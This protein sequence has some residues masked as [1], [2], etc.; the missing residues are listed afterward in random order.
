MSLSHLHKPVLEVKGLSLYIS[1]DIAVIVM[2]RGENRFNIDFLESMSIVLDHVEKDETCRGL[3][4]TGIGKFYSNGID[5]AWMMEQ[6]HRDVERFMVML[7]ELLKR[8]TIFPVPTVAA[9]NGHCFAG[10]AF[11][12]L[13]HDFRAMKDDG[14]GW[15]CFNEVHNN[16]RFRKP[17]IAFLRI[18]IGVGKAFMMQL[19]W[20]TASQHQR[21]SAQIWFTY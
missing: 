21:L 14:R 11:F 7:W 4:T 16:M 6:S 8:M 10:G 13:A 5:V 20:A 1:D 3:I 17:M 19:P 2:D 18:K 15:V 9:I 12:A